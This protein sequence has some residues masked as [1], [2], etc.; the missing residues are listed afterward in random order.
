LKGTWSKLFET[1]QDMNL[2]GAEN[3]VW[4]P[5]ETIASVYKAV[6]AICDNLPQADLKFYNSVN[7]EIDDERLLTLINNPNPRQSGNDFLQEWVGFYALYGESFIRKVSSIGQLIG[8][9]LPAQ[10]Y[11]LNPTKMQER[12]DAGQITAWNYFGRYSYSPEEIM[13]TKDFNPYNPI[14]GLPPLKPIED[15]I[16]IDQATLTYNNAYFKNF[17][18]LGQVLKS[19]HNLTDKQR[20]RVELFLDTKYKGAGKAF[21]TMVLEGGLEPVNVVSNHKEMDFVEQKKLMREEI[22]GIWRTPK[23]LFNITEDLNYAT[24][25]GQMRIFW[26]YTLMPIIRKFEDSFNRHIVQPYRPDIHFAFD[27]SKVPAFQEDFKERVLTAQVLTQIGFTP[28]EANEILGL[29]F[30]KT[31]WRNSWWATFSLNPVNDKNIAELTAPKPEPAPI[32]QAPLPA[33]PTPPKSVKKID[34]VWEA[35]KAQFLKM[36]LHRQGDIENRFER[37]V[38]QYFMELRAKILKVPAQDLVSMQL[39][40]DWKEQDL[41]LKKLIEPIM[42]EG[43]KIGVSIGESVL[44]RTKTV[45]DAFDHRVQSLLTIRMNK[46]TGVNDT[47]KNRLETDMRVALDEQIQTGGSLTMQ[48]DAL[49]EAVRQYFNLSASKARLIARTESAGAVNGGSMLYYESEGVNKK[50]W[51]TSHDELV[52]ESHYRCEKE[53]AIP[54]NEA[55]SNDLMYP[56]DQMS[57]DAGEVCNCRCSLLPVME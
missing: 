20:E 24:F 6:K 51:I 47:I 32:D 26:I 30:D 39:G 34:L 16:E 4:K 31:E 57:G 13:H 44:G 2:L 15:E 49:Q 53:G 43:I 14:R 42:L 27:F 50:R 12:I 35:K 29:G 25:M 54:M 19:E 22:L 23:A 28:N 18:M 56:S 5:Y 11:V 17:A 46:I 48:V 45:D 3:K 7:E 55:F 40:I 36:F 33:D 41:K 8:I 38:S 52:R 21:R 1:G 10:M 37:K 9:N